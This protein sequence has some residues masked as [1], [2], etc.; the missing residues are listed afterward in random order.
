MISNIVLI[1]YILLFTLQFSKSIYPQVIKVQF[2][3]ISALVMRLTHIL[4]F[5]SYL[6]LG[7]FKN[8]ILNGDSIAQS[9]N[10]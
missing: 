4:Q 9:H 1:K 10:L 7:L 8:F 3:I 2:C 5:T 6:L